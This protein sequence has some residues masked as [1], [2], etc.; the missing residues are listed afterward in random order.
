MCDLLSVDGLCRWE[1]LSLGYTESDGLPELRREVAGL[2]ENVS[3]EQI[4]VM[5]PQEAIQI[6]AR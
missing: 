1:N 2:Y 6:A 4:I 3:P 5:V